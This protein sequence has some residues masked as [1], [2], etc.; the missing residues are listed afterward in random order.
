MRAELVQQTDAKA[1]GQTGRQV[2][3]VRSGGQ[4]GT[5][6]PL[7]EPWP[8]SSCSAPHSAALQPLTPAP[9]P[10][11]CTEGARPASDAR[12]C[13]SPFV[14]QAEVVRCAAVDAFLMASRQCTMH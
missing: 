4:T 5:W 10:T 6:S 13:I 14:S 9:T 1:A 2:S 12:G 7:G 11:P 8:H 3:P